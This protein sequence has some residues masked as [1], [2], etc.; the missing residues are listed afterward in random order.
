MGSTEFLFDNHIAAFGTECDFHCVSQ[1]VD[2]ILK[3]FAS[4]DIEFYFFCH[5]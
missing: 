1:S 2:A 4:L 3:L 5:D